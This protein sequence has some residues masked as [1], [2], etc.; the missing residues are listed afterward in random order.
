MK[1]SVALLIFTIVCPALALECR[2][3][4]AQMKHTQ[5]ALY[6]YA[7]IAEAGYGGSPS[8]CCLV[9]AN[10]QRI[11]MPEVEQR[12]LLPQHIDTRWESEFLERWQDPPTPPDHMGQYIGDNGVT[13]VACTD[14]DIAPQLALTWKEFRRISQNEDTLSKV[15]VYFEIRPVVHR[16]ILPPDEEIGITYLGRVS[17]LNN[18]REE[19][20][21]VRGTDFTRIP[22][23]MASLRY[24][25]SNSY[26]YQMAAIVVD[27]IGDEPSAGHISAVGHSLGGGA[28]QY[29]VQDHAS[30]PWRNPEN[31]ANSNVMFAA[32]S[33]NA[34]GLDRSSANNAD[35]SNLHS[36]VVDGE[37][38]SWLGERLER[39]QA[40]TVTRFTPSRTWP[41][42]GRLEFVNDIIHGE[43][44]ESIRR[45][46]LPAVQ[47]GL[48]ECIN[49]Q[50]SIS[51]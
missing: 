18:E 48:C 4:S 38:V 15:D 42:T 36:Y 31:G 51:N 40:G 24:L 39:T 7:L 43:Q 12:P 47:Q 17:P 9:E 27:V 21:A 45:H 25:L 14:D 30:H 46:R 2:N 44:P 28:V 8:N 32:Y 11:T 23:I 29:I 50:G 20:V 1:S 3:L 6:E 13:Y 35:P 19:L 34:L 16:A 33:F 49:G 5:K 37:I 10:G 22:Q 41:E 26:V